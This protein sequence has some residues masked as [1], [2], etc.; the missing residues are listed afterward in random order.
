MTITKDEKRSAGRPRSF[1]REQLIEKVMHL[2]WDRGYRDLSFNE[3]ATATGLT[4]A[5]LYNSFKSKEA[6]FF[7]ALRNYSSST[8]D[9]LFTKVKEGEPVGP[10]F[11]QVFAH[12][13]RL[14]ATEEKKRGCF[15]VNCFSE[16]A[17]DDSQVGK[18]LSVLMEEKRSVIAGLINQAVRQKELPKGTDAET[19]A[20]MVMAFLSGFSLFSKGGA[21]EATLY[22][23][24]TSFL[25]QIGF[26]T[27]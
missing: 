23:M 8:P 25:K 12:A 11:Y 7:E 26:K 22:S 17:G 19:T 21:D 1:D 6:L 27:P 14:R 13:A 4:R 3:I 20:N 5:S 24:C 16:L 9:V 2:F 15:T 10:V 18:E